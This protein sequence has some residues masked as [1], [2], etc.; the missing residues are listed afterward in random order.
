MNSKLTGNG[1]AFHWSVEPE[2]L[3]LTADPDLMEQVMINLLLNA[4]RAVAGR[5]NPGIRLSA[6]L[7]PEGKVIIAVEDNGVGIVE[8]ALEK[9]FIP[10][11]TTN[12]QGSGIGL[13]L[14]RQIL[15]LH[16]AT[17]SA[18]SMP[19]QGAT[20]TMRFS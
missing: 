17:I 11:F 6:V 7:S 15:R 4:I 16:N 8:E 14:S 9:I 18:K 10:F 5:R 2:T 3:E 20:F 12:K 19:D 13:S 1:I